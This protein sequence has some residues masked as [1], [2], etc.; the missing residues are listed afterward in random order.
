M[1]PRTRAQ[2]QIGMTQPGFHARRREL[3]IALP[4]EAHDDLEVRMVVGQ[5]PHHLVE[6]DPV[7][8]VM[9][10]IRVPGRNVEDVHD[11]PVAE[12]ERLPP[13][14]TSS[15]SR[16]RSRRARPTIS[17]AL[18]ATYDAFIATIAPCG[19]HRGTSAKK[20]IPVS[21]RP[22]SAAMRFRA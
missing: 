9:S 17:V 18:V 22:A 12:G 19:P 5:R 2:A 4:P 14:A 11:M 10:R 7:H 1:P 20:P 6:E 13:P 3:A 16:T 8:Q 15:R 21:S